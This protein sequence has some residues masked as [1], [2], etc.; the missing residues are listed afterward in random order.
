MLMFQSAADCVVVVRPVYDTSSDV[1]HGSMHL[2]AAV[3]LQRRRQ[4][5]VVLEH[6]DRGRAAW[7]TRRRRGSAAAS[8]AR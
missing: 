5:G 7:S 1:A 8:S 4:L 2:R 6:R 3:A